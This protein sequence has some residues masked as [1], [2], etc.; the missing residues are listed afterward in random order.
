M[1]SRSAVPFDEGHRHAVKAVDLG[2][3]MGGQQRRAGESRPALGLAPELRHAG[4]IMR[5]LGLQ[6]LQGHQLPGGPIRRVFQTS[7]WPPCPSRSSSR[8]GPSRR[9]GFKIAGPRVNPAGSS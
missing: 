3:L 6:D 9:P 1:M 4:W 7:P 2:E 8:Y 5:Q